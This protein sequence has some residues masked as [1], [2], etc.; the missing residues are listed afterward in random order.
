MSKQF[1]QTM[2]IVLLLVPSLLALV[3]G[4]WIIIASVA[5]SPDQ[6]GNNWGGLFIYFAIVPIVIGVV[7][8]LISWLVLKRIASQK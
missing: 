6:N 2:T 1:K 8:S 5:S 3:I 4:T 7:G